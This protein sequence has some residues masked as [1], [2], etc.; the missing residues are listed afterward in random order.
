MAK[1][2]LQEVFDEITEDI[3]G[4]NGFDDETED[5][6]VEE[7]ES[8]SEKLLSI[9]EWTIQSVKSFGVVFE[10][11]SN[12]IQNL[13]I[14]GFSLKVEYNPKNHEIFITKKDGSKSK[15]TLRQLFDKCKPDKNL[16]YENSYQVYT[17]TLTPKQPETVAVKETTKK[18]GR[19]AKIDDV[20][21]DVENNKNNS[22]DDYLPAN[23]N[24]MA[25][26]NKMTVD[27]LKRVVTMVFEML[28]NFDY[29]RGIR[30]NLDK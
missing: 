18:R 3:N 1:N 14:P 4:G 25:M 19:P 29:I 16:D 17:Q 22:K 30:K 7:E 8:N 26:V 23:M 5:Q 6:F 13:R 9:E 12:Q 24:A 11:K 10:G 20:T 15:V 2:S 21:T 28:E 27:E